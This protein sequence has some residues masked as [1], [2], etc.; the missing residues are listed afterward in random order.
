MAKQKMTLTV[1]SGEHNRTLIFEGY[2]VERH[3]P[4]K[5]EVHLKYAGHDNVHSAVILDSIIIPA[6]KEAINGKDGDTNLAYIDRS[7]YR[8][9]L[10][11]YVEC[12]IW[13]S[14]PEEKPDWRIGDIE[15]KT[16]EKMDKDVI[17]FMEHPKVRALLSTYSGHKLSETQI[18]HDFWLTRG[19]YGVGFFDRG[20]PDELGD[21]LTEV[22]KEFRETDLYQG[23]DGRLYI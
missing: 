18:G 21:G 2:P 8:Y 20:L 11:A 1:R 23:D 19:G 6:I 13:T 16:L 12:A 10:M 4:P 9:V 7:P 15:P 14:E 5:L 3:D 17:A 22:C